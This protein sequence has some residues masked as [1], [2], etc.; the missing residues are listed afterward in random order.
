VRVVSERPGETHWTC[1]DDSV[2]LVRPRR[3]FLSVI[4]AS[5]A[6]GR[7][8]YRGQALSVRRTSDRT[9]GRSEKGHWL[10]SVA[11]GA[12]RPGPEVAVSCSPTGSVQVA[13]CVWVMICPLCGDSPGTYSVSLSPTAARRCLFCGLVV[14]A[15]RRRGAVALV[16]QGADDHSAAARK[17][18]PGRVI[19]F[20]NSIFLRLRQRRMP[21]EAAYG[22]M[23]DE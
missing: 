1:R 13:P 7:V 20:R 5:L 15:Y 8:F 22:R 16:D 10:G 21:R 4:A 17:E 3:T 14:F 12:V 23:R 19:A 9:G 2:G 18:S 11:S 6:V